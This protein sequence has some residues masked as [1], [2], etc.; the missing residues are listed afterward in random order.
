MISRSVGKLQIWSS[1]DKGNPIL[2]I[3]QN[4]VVLSAKPNTSFKTSTWVD[5]VGQIGK[6]ATLKNLKKKMKTI[7]NIMT[8]MKANT[9]N[10]Y[11][12]VITRT[13]FLARIVVAL[14]VFLAQ[15]YTIR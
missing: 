3:C 8:E 1:P 7:V 11:L 14:L 15:Q 10:R 6:L 4:M 5:L 9:L 2:M 13:F 12:T